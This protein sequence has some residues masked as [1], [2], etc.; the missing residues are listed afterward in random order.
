MRWWWLPRDKC[1]TFGFI[2]ENWDFGWLIRGVA[3]V[4]GGL[5]GLFCDLLILF[6]EALQ[7]IFFHFLCRWLVPGFLDVR[8]KLSKTRDARCSPAPIIGLACPGI[9]VGCL[10]AVVL[11]V[12][13]VL[14]DK[15][16]K[17]GRVL[18]TTKT[19]NTNIAAQIT[20]LPV[21][22]L[23]LLLGNVLPLGQEILHHE[24]TECLS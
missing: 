22:I 23:D 6:L 3:G 24:N 13:F 11:G 7:G 5:F 10:Q 19:K 16:N 2:I 18:A 17:Q 8:H 4:G 21:G 1:L 14:R 15:L 9:A 12:L 20:H